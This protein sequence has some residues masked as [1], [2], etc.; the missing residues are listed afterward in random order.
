MMFLWYVP[1]AILIWLA[2]SGNVS[3]ALLAVIG[4]AVA[5]LNRYFNPKFRERFLA[6]KT[7]TVQR[8]YLFVV[9]PVFLLCLLNGKSISSYD[10]YGIGLTASNLVQRGKVSL[11]PLIDCSK[12]SGYFFRCVNGEAYTT[13]PIGNLVFA[14]PVFFVAR[15]AGADLDNHK[16]IWRLSKLTASVVAGMCAGLF[17]LI[18]L[19]L[20]SPRAATASTMLLATGSVLLSTVGQG[21]WSHDGVLLFLLLAL[22]LILCRPLNYRSAVVIGLCLSLMFASRV[23]SA[24]LIAPLGLWF[25]FRAPRFA[26]LAGVVA[27]ISYLP[28]AAIHQYHFG[29]FLG[30]QYAITTAHASFFSVANYPLGVFGLLFSPGTG[31]FVYQPW[32]LLLLFVPLAHWKKPHSLLFLALFF[33]QLALMASWKEWTGQ[34]CWGTRYLTEVIPLLALIALPSIDRARRSWLVG[35]GVMAFLI[36]GNGVFG[37]GMNWYH[38][39]LNPKQPMESRALDWS[40]PAF[41]YPLFRSR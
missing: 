34:I 30:P 35:L 12:D 33:C 1:A 22:Y 24:V 15:L 8:T 14:V 20:S 38:H 18:A 3:H 16:V 23:A 39:P 19:S 28:W 32:L 5:L 11:S 27:V 21:L 29:H 26:V 4:V 36:Q 41:L 13:Y 7:K 17:F 25:L 10:N 31:L 6:F 2:L 37:P 9:L 40:D